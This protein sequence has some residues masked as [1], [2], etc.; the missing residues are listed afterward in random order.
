MSEDEVKVKA[1]N[2]S[3]LV[4]PR[5]VGGQLSPLKRAGLQAISQMNGNPEKYRSLR[6]TLTT[7]LEFAETRVRVQ[8]KDRRDTLAQR[9]MDNAVAA[10]MTKEEDQSD[11]GKDAEGKEPGSGGVQGTEPVQKEPADPD[12][13]KS[14]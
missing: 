13:N 10:E 1:R 8:I 7:L 14:G 3:E 5:D 12:A 9:L 11:E 2:V 4:F 6:D